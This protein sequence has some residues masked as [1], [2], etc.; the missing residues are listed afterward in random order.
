MIKLVS[1]V[2]EFLSSLEYTNF[3]TADELTSRKLLNITLPQFF[4]CNNT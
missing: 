4:N 1:E 2:L 3:R